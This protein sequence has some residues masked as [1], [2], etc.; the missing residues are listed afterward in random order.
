[1][2]HGNIDAGFLWE[3]SIIWLKMR[4]MESRESHMES[5]LFIASGIEFKKTCRKFRLVAARE[6]WDV[7]IDHPENIIQE[8]RSQQLRADIFSFMQRIPHFKPEFA[9]RMEMDN[10]A[11][12]PISSYEHWWTKQVTQEARN[13][14]RKALKKGVIVRLVEFDDEL[15]KN[16]R[17]IY[18]ESELRRG[19]RFTHYEKSFDEVKA[20]N[21]TFL[22]RACFIGAY[23]GSE[24]IG[25][26][27][28]VQTEG[29]TR[30]MGILAMLAHRDKAP[31][32]ALI[33]KAVEICANNKSPYL[34]YG[35]MIYGS[36][37]IDSLA[38]FK[39]ENGFVR[40][41]LPRYFVPLSKKGKLILAL[42]LH[43]RLADI[44]PRRLS[45]CLIRTRAL[46]NQNKLR[47]RGGKRR[48]VRSDPQGRKVD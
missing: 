9:Y 11:A 4:D 27:K 36:K 23:L 37:G 32:N 26:V 17:E 47:W 33:A 12:I 48:V 45:L 10:V 7:D 40:Y 35:K 3:L 1:M 6:E 16:I 34:T 25:F 43:K 22:E 38:Q 20:A 13:K 21:A 30:V 41:D 5:T 8:I 2:N 31:M 14:C 29:Y 18:R 39:K 28:L 24:L 46:V 42:H 19:A 44:L 15:V